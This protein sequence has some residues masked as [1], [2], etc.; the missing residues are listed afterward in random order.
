LLRPGVDVFGAANA[1]AGRT[2]RYNE[3]YTVA[4]L[5]LLTISIVV[6]YALRRLER[7]FD[8]AQS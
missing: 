5:L 2:F 4:A 7:R 8:R 6:A 3:P 1:I